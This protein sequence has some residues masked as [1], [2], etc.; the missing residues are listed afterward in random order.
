MRRLALA[1]LAFTV[2]GPPTASTAHGAPP[3][4]ITWLSTGDSYSSGEGVRG[5]VGDCAQSDEAWGPSAAKRLR[6]PTDGWNV[7]QVVFS[8]C[9]GHLVQDFFNGRPTDSGETSS[10]WQ[11]ALDQ[12]GAPASGRFDVI[13]MSFG[14]NDIGFADIILDCMGMPFH[15]YDTR[16]EQAWAALQPIMSLK[17]VLKSTVGA[18]VVPFLGDDCDAS[19][20]ELNRRV[21]ALARPNDCGPD[22]W[23]GGRTQY[24]NF[25]CELIIDHDAGVTGSISE[26]WAYVATQSL[27][28]DGV[29]VVQGYPSL[30]ATSSQWGLGQMLRCN[31]V[32]RGDANMLSRVASRLDQVL[33]DSVKAAN[34][35]LGTDRILYSS[36]LDLYANGSHSL[37]GNGDDWVNGSLTVTRDE[38]L[39]IP[40]GGTTVTTNPRFRFR[41]LGAFHPNAA[42]HSAEAAH[43]ADLLRAHGPPAEGE[44]S[45]PED[46]GESSS[47]DPGVALANAPV[48]ALCMHE[49]GNVVDGELPVE[50]DPAAPDRGFLH[51]NLEG[52]LSGQFDSDSPLEYVTTV[53]CSAGGVSWPEHL[54]IYDDDLSII[55]DIGI[56]TLWTNEAVWRAGF[57]SLEWGATINGSVAIEISAME[58]MIYSWFSIDALPCVV[59][60]D[61]FTGDPT[62]VDYR[63]GQPCGTESPATTLDAA[64]ATDLLRQY[65][66]AAGAR[67][68]SRAWGLLSPG[69]QAKYG[70]LARFASFWDTIDIVGINSTEVEVLSDGPNP[71]FVIHANLFFDL[72][73]GGRSTER[74]DIDVG[75]VD[76]V[77]LI[78]DYRVL[79]AR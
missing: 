53:R 9:T 32:T 74:V 3:A 60:G 20:A 46:P 23:R 73:D 24:L 75:V 51:L 61:T 15:E 45:E 25:D 59:V 47:L 34:L 4:P 76:G 71:K 39:F 2:V 43:V 63:T 44:S 66:L 16:I 5:N 48:P 40:V 62:Q 78:T 12:P 52:A 30:F 27:S 55:A 1:A 8:A 31:G 79:D 18:D 26:F 50:Q 36:I 54:L 10:L 68:Y 57:T 56:E 28:E 41:H 11:W 21:D 64:G 38:P 19:E 7:G 72:I 58:P 42:G 37:C 22:A 70:S 69:Y 65:L 29:M 13:T 14:G 35:Q 6:N 49:A 77:W 67:D 17:D 33:L